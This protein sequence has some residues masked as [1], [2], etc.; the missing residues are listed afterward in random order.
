[1]PKANSSAFRWTRLS[2][3]DIAEDRCVR[4]AGVDNP[5]GAVHSSGV[6]FFIKPIKR[7]GIVKLGIFRLSA[8]G[9]NV[10]K[11]SHA[12]ESSLRIC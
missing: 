5:R 9:S 7:D 2:N 3:R 10:Y 4:L 6:H 12:P 8:L 1:M 11:S